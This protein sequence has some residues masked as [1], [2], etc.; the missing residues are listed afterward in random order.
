MPKR[1]TLIILCIVLLGVNLFLY[2]AL[3]EKAHNLELARM[4]TGDRDVFFFVE[5]NKRPIWWLSGQTGREELATASSRLG[6]KIDTLHTQLIKADTTNPV[7]YF[8]K[9][10][11]IPKQIQDD[12]WQEYR[13]FDEAATA[14]LET[15]LPAAHARLVE[16]RDDALR[17]FN[18]IEIKA[19]GGAPGKHVMP[20][21]FSLGV[22]AH[23]IIDITWTKKDDSVFWDKENTQFMN[24]MARLESKVNSSRAM[25]AKRLLTKMSEIFATPGKL[26]V[27][28]E[29]YD[30]SHITN[31][32]IIAVCQYLGLFH[33]EM[34]ASLAAASHDLSFAR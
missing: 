28:G 18:E 7:A 12:L 32:E 5:E 17:Q 20:F 22:D 13:K 16:Q 24:Y 33:N 11:A 9:S 27:Y 30:L 6:D 3:R 8:T 2:F 23:Y 29:I 34:V 14:F 31:A 21:Y 15:D 19:K 25:Q 4:L 1:L 10:I 26:I